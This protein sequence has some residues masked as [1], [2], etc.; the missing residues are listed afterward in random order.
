RHLSQPATFV[1]TSDICPKQVIL[2]QPVTF[3]PTATLSQEATFSQ[4]ATSVRTS[5]ICPNQR[6]TVYLRM[7][8]AHIM[9]QGS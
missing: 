1:I 2:S 7:T 4:L 3:I 8:A 9:H 6:Q 5:D